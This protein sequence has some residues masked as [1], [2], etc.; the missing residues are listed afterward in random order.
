MCLGLRW[1]LLFAKNKSTVPT[2]MNVHTR[3]DKD[4][5]EQFRHW[6][7]DHNNT[8]CRTL[9]N[10]N[11]RQIQCCL[12]ICPCRQYVLVHDDLT[13]VGLEHRKPS[14]PFPHPVDTAIVP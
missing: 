7:G 13:A 2:L 5:I 10:I 14:D 6:L 12:L 8:G 11:A 9:G 1:P 4:R 3:R